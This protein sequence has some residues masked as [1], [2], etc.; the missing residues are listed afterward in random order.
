QGTSIGV[1]VAINTLTRNTAAI[2][3]DKESSPTAL[4]GPT[5]SSTFGSAATPLGALTVTATE[6]GNLVTSAIAASFTTDGPPPALAG[7]SISDDLKRGD[8]TDVAKAQK[9]GELSKAKYGVG[10]SGAFGLNLITADNALAYINDR[11]T[12]HTGDVSVTVDN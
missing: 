5:G 11:G 7:G 3:G 12:F 2:I 6:T 9:A 8:P 4:D 1:S 10:V